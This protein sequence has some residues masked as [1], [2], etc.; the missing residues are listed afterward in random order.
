MHVVHIKKAFVFKEK[1]SRV[2]KI[3]NG[4]F[5][6]SFARVIPKH[7]FVSQT[8]ER[9]MTLSEWAIRLLEQAGTAIVRAIIA[10]V[11]LHYVTRRN[12]C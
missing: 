1:G 9:M 11:I 4:R 10:G 5:I 3:L 7:T 6:V 12:G 2:P 8:I